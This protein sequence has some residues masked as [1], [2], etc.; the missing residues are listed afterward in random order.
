MADLIVGKTAQGKRKRPD[1]EECLNHTEDHGR[2]NSPKRQFRPPAQH[3][4]DFGEDLVRI[5]SVLGTQ[6]GA[7]SS[8]M[9]KS[10][11]EAANLDSEICSQ[12]DA[13][14][15]LSLE[16]ANSLPP[17]P[18][19]HKASAL[20]QLLRPE[21]AQLVRY[22]GCLSLGDKTFTRGWRV[23]LADTTCRSAL[24]LGII[25]RALK[26]HVFSVLYFG[27][28]PKLVEKLEKMEREEVHM[29]GKSGMT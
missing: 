6:D 14:R 23:L 5:D 7:P 3:E 29:D 21:N 17:I 19:E 26:E 28:D 10:A 25:G 22:I 13:I 16:L 2:V 20:S 8:D 24:V 9:A 12:M 4:D 27:G 15:T 11:T 18:S 1:P